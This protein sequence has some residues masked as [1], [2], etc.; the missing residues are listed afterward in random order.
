MVF[1]IHTPLELVL[2]PAS[3]TGMAHAWLAQ[4]R[5][6]QRWVV[7]YVLFKTCRAFRTCLSRHG[8][9]LQSSLREDVFLLSLSFSN[10]AA[11]CNCQH[12]SS[13]VLNMN[14]VFEACHPPS[15]LIHSL[16]GTSACALK[17]VLIGTAASLP[18]TQPEQ[19]R[20]EEKRERHNNVKRKNATVISIASTINCLYNLAQKHSLILH[21]CR[22]IS[23]C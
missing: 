20:K 10:F 23:I 7:C 12:P 11:R 21:I 4:R 22:G 5:R 13:N 15:A 19:E 1:P 8:N 16:I 14:F 6:V 3:E 18:P 2:V 9:G 17:Y